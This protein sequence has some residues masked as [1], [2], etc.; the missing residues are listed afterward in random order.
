MDL[1]K[2]IAV[3]ASGMQAQSTRMRIISENI[4]NADSVQSPNG[5]AYRRQTVHFKDVLD[6]Q[7]GMHKVQVSAVRR[8]TVTPLKMDYD[9][10]HPL[11]DENGFVAYPNVDSMVESVDMRQAQRA[12]EAN[13]AA[14]E[15]A[16]E[17]MTRSIDLLR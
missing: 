3:S 10:S 14:I 2:S 5:E 6:R 12:Y 17:M 15:S 8:D 13:M 4:A 9:P 11:A 16:K 7:T 1:M